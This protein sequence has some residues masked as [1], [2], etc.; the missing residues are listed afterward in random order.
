[1]LTQTGVAI[2]LIQGVT[3]EICIMLAQQHNGTGIDVT[4]PDDL[5]LSAV[6]SKHMQ[7]DDYLDCSPVALIEAGEDRKV[8]SLTVCS[9]RTTEVLWA[10]DPRVLLL[11]FEGQIYHR[12]A[13]AL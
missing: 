2:L 5:V 7:A 13:V 1:M 8:C 6:Q 3:S 9:V 10:S 11:Q 12:D 4:C